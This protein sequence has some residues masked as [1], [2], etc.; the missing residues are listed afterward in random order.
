MRLKSFNPLIITHLLSVLTGF[1][2]VISL[3][4]ILDPFIVILWSVL[5]ITGIIAVLKNR[6]ELLNPLLRFILALTLV[7]FIIFINIEKN[8]QIVLA[9]VLVILLGIKSLELKKQRDVFQITGLSVLGIGVASFLRFDLMLGIF[10]LLVLILSIVLMLWQHI[11][12]SVDT[13]LFDEK[14][15]FYLFV[16][17]SFLTSFLICVFILP[18]SFFFFFLLPRSFTP[19]FKGQSGF[20]VVKTGF[21]SKMS[22]GQMSEIVLSEEVAFRVKI[23]PKPENPRNLYWVGAVLWGTDGVDWVTAN[24][25]QPDFKPFSGKDMTTASYISQTITLPAKDEPFLFSLWRPEKVELLR[26]VQYFRDGT[27][28]L[29]YPINIP[30]RYTVYS[31]DK[32]SDQGITINEKRSGLFV[33]QNLD[34]RVKELSKDIKGDLTDS[35]EIARKIEIYL[36]KPPFKYSLKSPPGYDSGQSLSDF[37]IATKTGYCELYAS[38]MTILLRLSGI[39]A[40]VVIGYRGAEYN[41]MGEY[42]VVREKSAH[43]WVQAYIKGMGWINF[44]PTPSGLLGDS[45]IIDL[46]L[47][48]LQ[49]NREIS[50]NRRIW[51]WLQWQWANVIIDLT[52]QKQRLLW[53]EAGVKIGAVFQKDFKK[54]SF[55]LEKIKIDIKKVMIFLLFVFALFLLIYFFKS[56]GAIFLKFRKPEHSLR[57][58]AISRLIKSAPVKG[59]FFNPGMEYVYL[60][61]WKTNYPEKYE[62]ICDLYYLQRY[63]EKPS[64]ELDEELK[65]IL[66]R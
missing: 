24:P 64:R 31:S 17:F 21:S 2:V 15:W 61:W 55:S 25:D 27:L 39:P 9:F 33:P 20:S 66:V 7:F 13:K 40:R 23:D 58:K 10:L 22:P 1:V 6:S 35:F 30:I 56:K 42:W 18:L 26:G 11:V 53:R 63:G 46:A 51:D 34:N 49:E 38:S 14:K 37:L 50:D 43:A 36:K 28:K 32:I 19:L 45:Q 3:F 47:R 8:W 41:P 16:K 4:S 29:S 5:T 60:E 62:K 12:D 59:K 44:D 57:R 48:S 65:R 52:P 54:W